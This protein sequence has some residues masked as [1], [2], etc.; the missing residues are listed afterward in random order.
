[1]EEIEVLLALQD[2]LSPGLMQ[3]SQTADKMAD[4]GLADLKASLDK[5]ETSM[6]NVEAASLRTADAM[7]EITGGSD[8]VAQT[9]DAFG[10]L[11]RVGNGLNDTMS[12]LNDQFGISLGPAQ[13]WVGVGA[14]MG[15]AMEGMIAGGAGLVGTFKTIAT[16]FVPMIAGTWAHVTALYAQAAA[17]IVANAPMIALIAVIALIVAGIILLVTHWD[18]ITEKVPI[19]GEAVDAVKQVWQDFADWITGS[20]IPAIAVIY[21]TIEEVVSNIIEFVSSNWPTIQGI[22]ETPINAIRTHIEMVLRL[23]QLYIETWWEIISSMFKVFIALIQGDWETAWN[24]IKDIGEAIWNAIKESIRIIFTAIQTQISGVLDTIKTVVSGAWDTI[25]TATATGWEN[26]KQAIHDAL[27]NA[28]TSVANAILDIEQWM[29]DMPGN[30]IE[31]VSG[32]AFEFLKLG[33]SIGQ[34]FINGV[35]AFAGAIYNK[36]KEIGKKAWD[37]VVAGIGG[38]I[39][40]SPSQFGLDVGYAFG[41]GISEGFEDSLPMI[42]SSLGELNGIVDSVGQHMQWTADVIEASELQDKLE[43][44]RRTGGEEAVADF[45]AATD[46]LS[47]MTGEYERLGSELEFDRGRLEEWGLELDAEKD[48]LS[49][50]GDKLS[51]TKARFDDFRNTP[52]LEEESFNKALASLDTAITEIQLKI[53]TLKQQG[54][55]TE[56]ILDDKGKAQRVTTDIGNQVEILEG[57]LDALRLEAEKTRLEEKLQIEPLKDKIKDL[58]KEVPKPFDEIYSGA[59]EAKDSMEQLTQKYDLQKGKVD[60]LQ[61]AYDGLK[62][63]IDNKTTAYRNLGDQIRIATTELDRYVQ[64]ARTATQ[65]EDSGNSLTQRLLDAGVALPSVAVSPLALAGAGGA[66]VGNVIV[67]MYGDVHARDE[68]EARVAGRSIGYGI[69]G[70]VHQRGLG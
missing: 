49:A 64:I 42:E 9:A 58:T 52:L 3:A 55:L 25:K 6:D 53:V 44:I 33:M 50:L 31:S 43:D 17:F 10:N 8:K 54:P 14:Q 28:K 34:A 27:N 12:V 26:I 57:Q 1:M 16:N 30:I 60:T 29:S 35:G 13:E 56:T 69:L 70:N 48:R 24:E 46:M 45:Q 62:L 37:G 47:T 5:V 2:K 41:W 7:E 38:L 15:G 11:E 66:S 40:G 63:S 67:N 32:L 68:S 21:T 19:L 18:T 61:L 59:L 20:L 51:D 23:I 36:A 22:V 39:P 4:S 65:A